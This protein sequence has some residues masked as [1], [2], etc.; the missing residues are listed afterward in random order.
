MIVSLK[1]LRN[2]V[3]IDISVEELADRLTMVGLEV[4]GISRRHPLSNDIV[5]A[6][7]ETV[8]SH[9]NATRLRICGVTARGGAFRVVCGAPNVEVGMVAPLALPGAVLADG[10]TLGEAVIRGQVSQGML[11]SRKELG[12][13][14]DS[15]GI[16]ALPPETPVGVPVSEALGLDDVIVEVSI[17]PNRADCLSIMG[18]AREVSAVCKSPLRYPAFSVLENGPAVESLSS[19]TVEDPL[20]CP[21]YSARIVQGVTVGPSPAWLREKVEAVGIRSI[22][23]IVDV[24]NFIL[25]ELGQ[26]LHAFDFDRLREHRIVVRRASEGER[27]KTL[28]GVER[29]LFADSLLI[30]DGVGPV[31]VAGIMGGENSEIREETKRVLIESAYFDP[32]CIRR[33]GKKLGLRSESSYRFE[34][35]IDPD[36]VIRALDRAAQLMVEVGGGE[37]AAGCIDVYPSP[38]KAPELVLRTARTNRFLGTD[39]Q[40]SEMIEALQRIEMKVEVL[41]SDRLKVI[42]PSFRPDV[43]REVDLTEEIARLAGYD[44]VPV[45]SPA[46]RVESAP[47]DP[48]LRSRQEVKDLLKGSGFSEVITYSFISMESLRKLRLPPDDPRLRPIHLMNPLSEEQAVMRTSLVPGL[49][50]TAVHNF[51]RLNEDL[52]IYELSKV[53]LPREDDVLPVE[54]HHLAGL[55]SGKRAPDLLYGSEEEVDY[56]DVKGM[57]EMVIEYFNLDGLRFASEELPPYFDSRCAAAVFCGER[58]IGSVGRL[59]PAVEEAFDFKKPVYLFELDFDGIFAV[60]NPFPMF[61]PLP[62][63]PAVA[64]DMAIVANEDL[65]VREP[66]EF[67][68]HQREG[69][70]EKVELFDVYRNPQLG[71]GRKSVGYRLVYR[72][73]DRS[74]TDEEVNAVHNGLVAKVLDTFHAVLR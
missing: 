68:L 47:I 32:P 26:P 48:H 63:F 30:C 35:G 52:R 70:L 25:M 29:R 73:A 39:L 13:E 21:R 72:A 4:E 7:V 15:S 74:L 54:T 8:E 66:L 27:F 50:H 31:A 3:E 37:V 11:C 58:R 40:V 57:V 20:G 56:T 65:R 67:I 55:A 6:R 36:G 49:L 44:R 17:T 71:A 46:A 59:H 23:N 42:P 1:W 43:T 60:T 64:R 16:W 51:G 61:T 38:L 34:R 33:T 18:I 69:L 22:N 62:R 19:V 53:F 9:P 24:T 41:D 45:T 14:G 10:T 2:Y 12:I 5:T 28:D